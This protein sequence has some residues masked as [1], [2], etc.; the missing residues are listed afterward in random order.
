[1]ASNLH[2]VPQLSDCAVKGGKRIAHTYVKAYKFDGFVPATG[3]PRWF[4]MHVCTTCK[5]YIVHGLTDV[6]PNTRLDKQAV[7]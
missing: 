7:G 4:L 2:I 1:M 5:G 6:N 3:K